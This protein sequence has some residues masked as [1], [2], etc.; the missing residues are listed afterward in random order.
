M[1]L[2]FATLLISCVGFA[3]S[4]VHAQ[5]APSL[6]GLFGKPT[7]I[8]LG[9]ELAKPIA[10][11]HFSDG[12]MVI[13]DY[14]RIDITKMSADGE[15]IWRSGQ[16]GQGPGEYLVPYRVVALT[17]NSVI[18]YDLSLGFSHLDANG[19]YLEQL[20]SDVEF[21]VDDIKGLPDGNIVVL[22]TTSDVRGKQFAMH[23]LTAKLKYVKS[24]GRLP[25]VMD[26]RRLNSF[27]AGGVNIT[28]DG[29]LLHTRFYPYEISK[30]RLDGTEIY[31]LRPPLTVATPEAYVQIIENGGRVQRSI[32]TT[33]MRPTPAKELGNGQLLGGRWKGQRGFFDLIN[34]RGE[35]IATSPIPAGWG[36]ISR[37]DF[38][39]REFWLTGEAEDVPVL[40]RV[41]FGRLMP[42]SVPVR[43]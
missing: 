7:V 28:P 3:R 17:D 1:R 39:R 34:S 12:S 26:P 6:Q 22:G 41:P 33:V 29:A 42:T 15:V 20:R 11:A 40:F 37:I 13:A 35:I 43:K 21:N 25:E 19:K 9:A 27:G 31:R 23:I 18:V 24:F 10:Y 8:G 36:F 32:N 2:R 5:M 16:K 30:Y 4:D 14:G 38:D